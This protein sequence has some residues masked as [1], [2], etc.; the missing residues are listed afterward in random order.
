MAITRI[1]NKN[2]RWK[3]IPEW[4][5]EEEECT[6]EYCEYCLFDEKGDRVLVLG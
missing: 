2:N 4:D 3:T 1:V 5:E 6:E